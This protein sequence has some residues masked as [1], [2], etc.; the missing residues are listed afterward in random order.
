M[1]EMSDA[2]QW[3]PI[4]TAPKDG[5]MFLVCLPRM[6]NLILRANYNTVH[7]YFRTD[8]SDSGITNPTFFHDGDY[9][10]PLP[11]PPEDEMVSTHTKSATDLEIKDDA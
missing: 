3:Q 4:E 10:M 1:L 11:T 6:M 5:Q 7:G 9:W 2:L 8:H